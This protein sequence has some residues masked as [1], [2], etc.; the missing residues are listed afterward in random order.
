M[1]FTGGF[2]HFIPEPGSHFSGGEPPAE[3]EPRGMFSG[4]IPDRASPQFLSHPCRE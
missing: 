2:L 3:T 4:F 1:N